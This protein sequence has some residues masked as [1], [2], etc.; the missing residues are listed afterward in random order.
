MLG[1]QTDIFIKEIPIYTVEFKVSGAVI[2]TQYIEVGESAEAPTVTP[3]EGYNFVRWDKSF[4]NVKSNLVVNAVLQ[5]KTFTVRFF[6]YD[7]T[8]LKTSTVEYGKAAYCSSTPKVPVGNRFTSWDKSLN[9]IKQNTD[10]YPL[11]EL[12]NYTIIWYGYNNA[13]IRQDT[14]MHYGDPITP[15]QIPTPD[16]QVCLGWTTTVPATVTGDATF[17][18]TFVRKWYTVTFYSDGQIVSQQT[19]IYKGSATAPTVSKSG[20]NFKGW[21]REFTN[22][23]ADISVN[24]IWKD[25]YSDIPANAKLRVF[26]ETYTKDIYDLCDGVMQYTAQVPYEY[27][28]IT[29]STIEINYGM[30]S[31]DKDSS[32]ETYHEGITGIYTYR[33]KFKIGEIDV[34]PDEIS[35]IGATKY[36]YG[37]KGEY[38]SLYYDP[39]T[40]TTVNIQFKYKNWTSN[41]FNITYKFGNFYTFFTPNND[42]ANGNKIRSIFIMTMRESSRGY[43]KIE[44]SI[45]IVWGG[46]PKYCNNSLYIS[47]CIPIVKEIYACYDGSSN[48]QRY[49]IYPNKE[50]DL[51]GNFVVSFLSYA[52]GNYLSDGRKC[53]GVYNE[54]DLMSGSYRLKHFEVILPDGTIKYARLLPMYEGYGY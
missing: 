54:L 18:S 6:N 19:V 45:P 21:D 4:N 23:T 13:L 41:R 33:F 3:P 52:T 36:T 28:E 39:T 30:V 9:D 49:K 24:A 16:D 15:P 25:V 43:I 10:F 22:V 50:E 7:S 44:P 35:I 11:Y 8:V 40:P 47:K 12:C 14:N 26:Q 32:G 2:N 37:S 38:Y 51:R 48:N 20:Y 42:D 5:I 29:G 53:I 34:S 17:R 31:I 46:D 27:R 1:R